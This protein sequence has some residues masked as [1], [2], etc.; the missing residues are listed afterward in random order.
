MGNKIR[1]A[2]VGG[3]GYTGVELLRLLLPHPNVEL[4]AITGRSEAGKPVSSIYPSLS[5]HTDL[6]FSR[7]DELD[8]STIDVAFLAT[9]NGVAMR[10]AKEL[11]E[12]GVRII[13]LSA[14]FR[15]KDTAAYEQW[16]GEPHLAPSLLENAVYGLCEWEADAVKSAQ[17]VANPGCYPTAVQLALIPLIKEGLVAGSIIADC[18]SGVSGAGRGANVGTLLCEASDTFKAYGASGHR[19]LPEIRQGLDSY[20][21]GEHLKDI[22]FTPH[23][24]PM[25]RG[26]HATLHIETE[27][28]IEQVRQCL[29]R[30]YADQPFVQLL[31]DGALPETRSVKSSNH[32]QI[33]V[34][35][36]YGATKR[37]I[38]CSVID[39]L[40]KGAAGQAVQNFNLMHDLPMQSGLAMLPLVP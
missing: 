25:I 20:D 31:S 32:C 2:V 23:L 30:A 19:H 7:P 9:P 40:M 11:V 10:M 15:L 21:E 6:V 16:Y 17:I 29:E 38:L 39:N 37:L 14:D 22:V 4:V 26:I 12:A 1:T 8:W 18:K 36:P 27:A 24:T 35:K 34:V 5:G 3:T 28:T 33:G 13:D